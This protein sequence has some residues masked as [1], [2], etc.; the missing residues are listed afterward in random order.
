MWG[1][2]LDEMFLIYTGDEYCEECK[3][4][5]INPYGVAISEKSAKDIVF[6]LNNNIKSSLELR[7][8]C[9]LCKLRTYN[10]YWYSS[11]SISS[12]K[13]PTIEKC[14]VLV[15]GYCDELDYTNTNHDVPCLNYFKRTQVMPTCL[16]QYKRIKIL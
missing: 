10:H 2:N 11:E 3:K 5:D 9:L 8:R 7:S 13:I 16:Y 1:D 4:Y 6:K 15:E 14:N 12:I